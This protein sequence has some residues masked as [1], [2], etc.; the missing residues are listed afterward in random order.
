MVEVT[1]KA[2]LSNGRSLTD[3]R[4]DGMLQMTDALAA[5]LFS[6]KL[7]PGY[8]FWALEQLLMMFST[9]CKEQLATMNPEGDI[10]IR[11]YLTPCGVG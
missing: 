2:L 4:G 7:E 5:C 10:Y 3:G 11:T 6:S 9:T 8:K 1:G